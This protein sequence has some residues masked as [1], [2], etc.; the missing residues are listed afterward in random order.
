M[1]D[2]VGD[3]GAVLVGKGVVGALLV[4]VAAVEA[5]SL[6]VVL[7]KITKDES[8]SHQSTVSSTASARPTR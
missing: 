5:V 8:S 4:A 7:L 3:E 6:A 1:G 2:P